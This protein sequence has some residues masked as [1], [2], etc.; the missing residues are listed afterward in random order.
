[1]KHARSPSQPKPSTPSTAELR[2]LADHADLRLALYRRR[3]Y[4]GRGNP[5]RYAEL[6]RAA[7]G[8][9]ARFTRARDRPDPATSR[10][11]T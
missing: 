2:D 5:R 11:P 10:E 3:L 8:A 9:R 4:L 6:E 1:M 7:H